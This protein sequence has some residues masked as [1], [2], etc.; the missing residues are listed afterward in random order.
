LCDQDTK[1]I[2]EFFVDRAMFRHYIALVAIFFSLIG[3]SGRVTGQTVPSG[4]N[5]ALVM[6][7]F[8]AP[9]GFTFDA[10]G[11]MYVWEKGGK[12]WIVENGVRLPSPLVDISAEVGNWRDHGCL[13]FALDPNFLSNGRIYLYYL[14][15]RHHL[16]HFG[17]PSYSASTN[18]YFN[19]TIM[20][21]TRYTAIGHL[22]IQRTRQPIRTVGVKRKRRGSLCCSNRTARGSLGFRH[23]WHIDVE[24][25]RCREL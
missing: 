18:E 13:G 21:C 19:A 4:F 22:S 23:G 7:G 16:L 10:N 1:T 8:D 11:R 20:R 17:T 5:D 3:P 12:V 24:F 14:V 15:D 6:A 25:G 2:D 9:V